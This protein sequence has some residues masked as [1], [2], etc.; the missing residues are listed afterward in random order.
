M[1]P[2]LLLSRCWPCCTQLG[3][4]G[5]WE[6]TWRER[7]ETE[8]L[9]NLLKKGAKGGWLCVGGQAGLLVPHWRAKQV[10]VLQA[11]SPVSWPSAWGDAVGLAAVPG[12]GTSWQNL[13][14]AAER[15]GIRLLFGG[16]VS[17][18]KGYIWDWIVALLK[19]RVWPVVVYATV[20]SSLQSFPV[21]IFFTPNMSYAT[22]LVKLMLL[23]R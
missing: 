23:R 6:H 21:F 12:G 13:V 14:G 16:S 5:G 1:Y 9:G 11:P 19:S 22:P 18:S 2:L 20:N 17:L 10:G 7:E 15:G 4:T 3:T 8:I